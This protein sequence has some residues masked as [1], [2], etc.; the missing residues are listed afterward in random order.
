MIVAKINENPKDPGFVSQPRQPPGL[1]D[2]FGARHQNR[3]KTQCAKWLQNIRIVH[4]I[5]QMAITYINI[6]Q[7]ETLKIFSQ[8]GIFGLKTCHLA[9]LATSRKNVAQIC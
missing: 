9:T 1:P 6:F 2:F 7:S 3:N 4:K 8:I 5:F